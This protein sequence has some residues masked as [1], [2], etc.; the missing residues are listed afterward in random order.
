MS[1][2]HRLSISAILVQGEVESGIP[3]GELVGG[4]GQGIRII[5]KAGGFGTETA[6]VKSI[7]Y[8]ERGYLT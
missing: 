2:C 6:L 5:T 3:A 4:Q 1:V 7:S 8:L